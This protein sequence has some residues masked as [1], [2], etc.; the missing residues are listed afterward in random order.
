MNNEQS[1]SG[2]SG[3][4]HVCLLQFIETQHNEAWKNK[5]AAEKEKYTVVA[6]LP[7]YVTAMMVETKFLKVKRRVGRLTKDAD[8]H[9]LWFGCLFTNSC[10]AKQ[11]KH[12]MP[13]PI[14]K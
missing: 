13:L 11:M 14:S 2:L 3:F 12:K 6:E 5:Q 8:G 9:L 10:C 7:L 4:N 1:P